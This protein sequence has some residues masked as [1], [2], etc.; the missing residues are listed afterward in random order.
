MLEALILWLLS[1]EMCCALGQA[2]QL[3]YQTAK[4]I[5]ERLKTVSLLFV[6]IWWHLIGLLTDLT[7][8]PPAVQTWLRGCP[9]FVCRGGVPQHRH[10]LGI[11]RRV[12]KPHKRRLR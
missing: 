3:Q 8:S 2:F 12:W 10:G 4:A 6:A 5:E 7:N 1:R 9:T 11:I